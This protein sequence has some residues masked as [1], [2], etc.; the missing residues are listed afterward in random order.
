MMRPKLLNR[1]V[2]RLGIA[3]FVSLALNIAVAANARVVSSFDELSTFDKIIGSLSKPSIGIVDWLMGEE[4]ILNRIW[5]YLGVSFIFYTILFW[6]LFSL[7]DRMR[8]A[9]KYGK[10]THSSSPVP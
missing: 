4:P 6:L 3:M 1:H 8:S 2:E 10:Q 9:R 5:I 7:W